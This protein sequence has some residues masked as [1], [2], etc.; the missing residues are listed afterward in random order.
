MAK[1][2][3]EVEVLRA[4]IHY[5][6]GMA[7]Q[8]K[9]QVKKDSIRIKELEAKLKKLHPAVMS[10]GLSPD[11]PL[12]DIDSIFDKVNSSMYAMIETNIK[13]GELVDPVL[14]CVVCGGLEITGSHHHGCPVGVLEEY[15]NSQVSE[16]F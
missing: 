12:S 15:A 2:P 3:T 13:D 8:Y 9:K 11:D 4:Q 7:E 14:S 1:E 16:E 5:C 10:L 6:S